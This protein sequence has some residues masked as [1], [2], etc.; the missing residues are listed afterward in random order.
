MAEIERDLDMIFVVIP[1]SEELSSK[2]AAEK[3]YVFYILI[4]IL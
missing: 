2:L 4:I 1:T 3:V